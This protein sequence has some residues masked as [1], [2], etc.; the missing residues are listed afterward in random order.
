VDCHPEKLADMGV[1]ANLISE[2]KARR[3]AALKDLERWV[4][5][6]TDLSTTDAVYGEYEA[7]RR[8]REA[9]AKAAYDASVI[10]E[11]N[12]QR[13]TEVNRT[14]TPIFQSVQRSYEKACGGIAGFF[15]DTKTVYYSENVHTGNQVTLTKRSETRT[16]KTLGSG[17]VVYGPWT[18]VRE[19]T[20]AG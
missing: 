14:S 12:E 13:T 3:Q 19:W 1:P 20:E 17:Q 2:R 11:V 18:L 7:R 10:R 6:Q 8:A 16:V 4:N 5:S 9:Q 15:G